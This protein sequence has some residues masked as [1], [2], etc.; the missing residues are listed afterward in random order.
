MS[1]TAPSGRSI[2]ISARPVMFEQ[3]LET[4]M[5][6]F[7]GPTNVNRFRKI[8]GYGTSS[9]ERNRILQALAE[10]WDAFIQEC[11]MAGPTELRTRG[12]P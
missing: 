4:G 2:I 12:H 5:A 6:R 11:H 1:P 9:L 3:E 10:E 8:A 7:L